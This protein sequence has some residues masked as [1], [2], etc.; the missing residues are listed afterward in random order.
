MY[1]AGPQR[2]RMC[3][4]LGSVY[5]L[6]RACAWMSTPGAGVEYLALL[7]GSQ[8][9]QSC[10]PAHAGP[11]KLLC[12]VPLTPAPQMK[13]CYQGR[14][15]RLWGCSPPHGG[16]AAPTGLLALAW[17]LSSLSLPGKHNGSVHLVFLQP[18]V[19]FPPLTR[20]PVLKGL[21]SCGRGSSWRTARLCAIPG[22]P[23]LCP[24]ACVDN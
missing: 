5:P 6:H 7:W 1:V 17:V 21:R 2:P 22:L 19:C 14:A 11:V 10:I 12:S 18:R 8:P 20:C 16:M 9:C 23:G 4:V 24:Y 3:S 15:G 13:G